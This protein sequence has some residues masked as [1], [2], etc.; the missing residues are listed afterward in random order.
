MEVELDPD[1]G[2]DVSRQR[3]T[4]QGGVLPYLL[5]VRTFA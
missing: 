2:V 1:A 4:V 5:V 3:E